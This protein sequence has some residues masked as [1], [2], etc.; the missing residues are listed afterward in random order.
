MRKLSTRLFAFLLVLTLSLSFLSLLPVSAAEEKEYFVF[1]ALHSAQGNEY[2]AQGEPITLSLDGQTTFSTVGLSLLQGDTNSLFFSL[3]NHSNATKIRVSYTYELYGVLADEQAEYAL[4]AQSAQKQT[5]VLETPHIGVKNAVKELTITFV[6]EGA[7]SGSV[8]LN[9]MFNISSYVKEM[10][11]E[12]SFSR[13]HY[14]DQTGEIEIQG[15][16]S[17]AATVRYEGETLALFALAEGEDLHLS[18]KMPIART[19]VSFNFSFAV[20][21]QSSDARFARYVVAAVTA[22]GERIPLCTPTYPSFSAAEI[23]REQGFKGMQ[24]AGLGEMIDAVPDVGVVDVY[25]DRLLSTQGDGVLYTGEYDYY[26]FDQSYLSDVDT[27]IQNLTAIG[28][29]VYLRLLIDGTSTGLSFVDEAP[30]GVQHRLPVIRSKQAQRDLFALTDFLSARYAAENQISGLILGRAADLV[31]TYSYCASDSLFEYATLYAASLNLVVGAARRNIPTLQVFLPVSDRIFDESITSLQSTQNY[32]GALFLPSLLKALEAQTLSPQPFA[33][34]LESNTLTD[35]VGGETATAYGTDRLSVLL[36]DLQSVA[37]QSAYLQTD[38][39]FSWQPPQNVTQAELRADYLLK[40]AAL[41]QNASIGAFLLDLGNGLA[42]DCVKAL[43][44]MAKYI[45][46]DRYDDF[47]GSALEVIGLRSI[48]DVYPSLQSASFRQRRICGLSLLTNGYS[49]GD[50]ITGSY[51][52]WDFSAATDSL[53][54]YAG[55]GCTSLSVVS[56]EDEIHALRGI[57][58]SQGD[59]ADISYHFASPVDLSFAPLW[60]TE[61]AV[62]GT[63]GTRYEIQIRLIGDQSVAYASAIV[64]AGETQQLFLNFSQNSFAL[65]NLRNVRIM[66]RPLDTENADFELSVSKITIESATLSNDA[67]TECVNAVRQNVAQDQPA[68]S[69]KKDHTVP[70]LIT[71]GVLLIS[72]LIIASFII[73]YRVKRKRQNKIK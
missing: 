67:L 25:L 60:K 37:A 12:A 49:T 65:F 57:C 21:A 55:N 10:E 71:G 9:A 17:Y 61:L 38:I 3:V 34:L 68:K 20:E 40:Y 45:N 73:T 64:T 15:S 28:A 42:S 13:C 14:N 31:Q 6:G 29:H 16:L 47:C 44:H 46:T 24:G 59:Y 30:E 36:A 56:K 43:A 63:A 51:A 19:N 66:A 32:Y 41:Y 26:Y 2:P 27:Q 4:T 70:V 52:F 39:F 1:D 22:N 33:I 5:I 11:E 58:G 62:I 72:G 18:S 23:P 53:G 54:W 8:T 35:L 7:I 69:E 48:A 50:P